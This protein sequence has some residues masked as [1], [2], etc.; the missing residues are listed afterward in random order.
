MFM[1]HTRD[2]AS[3]SAPP[4]RISSRTE[5]M[6]QGGPS[7][8]GAAERLAD[9]DGFVEHAARARTQ[10]RSAGQR[11]EWRERHR[12]PRRP[13]GLGRP[14]GAALL[15]CDNVEQGRLFERRDGSGT[16]HRTYYENLAG[17]KKRVG[18]FYIG[19]WTVWLRGR[20]DELARG[21]NALRPDSVFDWIRSHPAAL[22]GHF[23][24]PQDDDPGDVLRE[25][26]SVG[27]PVDAVG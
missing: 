22:Q 15:G 1:L 12:E 5:P 2:R 13:R 9:A 26:V 24:G 7:R 23:G 16:R 6:R 8:A 4:L 17:I 14:Q 10:A 19:F 11:I 25:E 21:Q 20:R 18:G 3:P 27:V